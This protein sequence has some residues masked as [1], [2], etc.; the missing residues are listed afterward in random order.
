MRLH[1]RL[2]LDSLPVAGPEERLPGD[3]VKPTPTKH[4]RPDEAP[5]PWK[6]QRRRLA[7]PCLT[8]DET[9]RWGKGGTRGD[10]DSHWTALVTMSL[11]RQ[12]SQKRS[13][14]PGFRSL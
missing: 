7:V 3:P 13:S 10:F 1:A 2:N 9:C 11:L 14:P 4:T 8:T 5:K 12:C 6:R